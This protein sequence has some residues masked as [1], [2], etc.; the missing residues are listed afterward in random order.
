[1]ETPRF[2]IKVLLCNW[3]S[4]TL[5]WLRRSGLSK[6]CSELKYLQNRAASKQTAEVAPSAISSD[7]RYIR[8]D[9][10]VGNV[11]LRWPP[12]GTRFSEAM[13]HIEVERDRSSNTLPAGASKHLLVG[14]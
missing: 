8:F 10:E 2:P 6:N 4:I 3:H 13:S 14:K 9:A 12:L 5:V 7:S 1:M 11:L